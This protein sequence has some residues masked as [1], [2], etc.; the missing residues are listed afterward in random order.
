[1]FNVLGKLARP[2]F[3]RQNG[4]L[5]AGYLFMKR[6]LLLIYIFGPAIAIFLSVHIV[7]AIHASSFPVESNSGRLVVPPGTVV[8]VRLLQAISSETRAGDD[9]QGVTAEAC[10][11]GTQLLIPENTRALVQVQDIHKGNPEGANVT[12]QL[13]E[14]LFRYRDVPVR[15][16]PITARLDRLSDLDLMSRAAGGLIGGAVGAAS[17]ASVHGNPDL[18]ATAIGGLAAGANSEPGNDK[19]ISFQIQGPLDLT[20]IRW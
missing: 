5:A 10:F 13:S 8:R 12:M 11:S 7:R 15:T 9:L 18:G 14:F 19:V 2:K 17:S 6:V 16:A 1:L 20:G 3:E 4:M